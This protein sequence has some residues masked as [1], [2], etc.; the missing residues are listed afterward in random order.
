M[1]ACVVVF[2]L[3]EN[4]LF[5]CQTFNERSG[6]LFDRELMEGAKWWHTNARTHALARTRTHLHSHARTHSHAQDGSQVHKHLCSKKIILV[7]V[8]VC[9]FVCSS[10]VNLVVVV[11]AAAVVVAAAVV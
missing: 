1:C 11:A 5:F 4:Q 10:S 9:L 8:S 7:C 3:G 6:L 2:T